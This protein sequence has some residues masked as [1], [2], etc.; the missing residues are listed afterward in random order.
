[1][2]L[3]SRLRNL[4]RRDAVDADIAEE[5][6]SHIDMAVEE[7]ICAGLSE[8]EAWRAA[9]LRFGN[10][11]AMR[12]KTMG[13]DAALSLEGFWLD[14][15]FALRQLKRSP[16][17]AVTAM[18]TLALGIGANI[19]VFGVLNA[20]ILHPLKIADP[21]SVHQI[22][23]KEWM[24][25]GPSYPA[26]E[27]FRRRN[28]TFAGMAAVYGLSS[29]G[30]EWNNKVR[31]VSGYD[32]T[33]N[34]FDLLGVQPEIG[35]FFHANDEHG[36]G[37]APYV[38]LSDA[39]WRH[40]FRADP[41]VIGK[42][43]SLSTH[44]FTVVGVAPR[45]FHGLERFF[46]PDYFV[47]M[48][49][50]EQ[51]EGWDFLHSRLY[52]PVAVIGRLKPGVTAERA[53]ENL[54][55]IARDL[56]KE[57]PAT[58]LEQSARLIRPGLEGDDGV[59]IHQ[60]L[61]GVML[62]ALLLL[63]A[64]CANLAS[65]FAARAADRG[66]ELA[67][68]VALGSSR[69]RLLWQLL[70]EALV[71]SLLG[72]AVGMFCAATLL[73]ALSRWQPFGAGSEHLVVAVDAGVYLAG[74]A[75]SVMSGLLFGM[76]PAWHAWQS[77]PLQAIKSAPA[78]SARL[79]TFAIRDVLLGAQIAICTLL[80][81]ASLVAIRGMV[82]ALHA[83]L[84]IKPAGATV[85]KVN[86]G[87]VGIDG[88]NALEKQKQIID[89]A[90]SI[91]GVQ[92]A[93]IVNFLPLSGSGMSGIPVYWP[94]TVDQTLSNQVLDTRVYPISPDYLKAA[95][96]RLLTGRNFTWRDEAHSPR[97]AIVNATFAHKMFGN[98]PAVGNHFLLWKDSYEV[99]GVAE[100]GKYVDLNE[101]PIC[102]VYV[103]TAQM[104]QSST[105][106]VVR[107]SLTSRDM[108]ASLQR[109]LSG[110][111]PTA[112][113]TIR[114]WDDALSNVL[115]PAR[116][117]A[118]ALGIMGMLAA[119]LAVT[120]IFGMAA[121]SVSK[122]MKELGIRIALGA[123]RSQILASAIGRPLALLISGSIVGLVAGLFSSRLLGRIVYQADPSDPLVVSGVIATMALLGLTATL[124]PARRA[125][126]VD[127][128][129]LM[130]EE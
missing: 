36:P 25:G 90:E 125:V 89:A 47:P 8:T 102:A 116:T 79:R 107:S 101:D 80:V 83:P 20:V 91:P 64:A 119:M 70:T 55:A 62:L 71:V 63:T 16:G 24:S 87:M 100:S 50:E 61:F 42:T 103:S 106:L 65:L 122:R 117:A 15:K 129:R 13:A 49:N 7:G 74:L 85:A 130:R 31:E 99:I 19:V 51:V 66:R 123:Q 32:V 43:V 27:D 115:F 59:L 12:E 18:V 5:L 53:T 40:E 52:E 56:Q 35:R 127:A 54:N 128:A 58:D 118:A 97:V 124:I 46:W 113:I 114:S 33:G 39:L 26:F 105:N 76:I 94:G 37:S 82:R 23:H 41:E 86:F 60:F 77:R 81:T 2:G 4:N 11:V 69:Q 96:T 34:Y 110:I 93:G 88:D 22:Y 10:P 28:T 17:F 38:V 78:E 9:R 6:R 21:Q 109:M 45:D 111:A 44:P 84:G 126:T 30:L 121:Y 48:V 112:P 1:M 95:G 14:V 104:E 75:L 57:Y 29:V 72:G 68:R 67:L 92:A 120:G 3:W 108:A 73:G 98:R